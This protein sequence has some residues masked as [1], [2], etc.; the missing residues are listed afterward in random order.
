[1]GMCPYNYNE[2]FNKTGNNGSDGGAFYTKNGKTQNTKNQNIVKNQ[3]CNNSG[4]A[5]DHGYKSMTGFADGVNVGLPN[6]KGNQSNHHNGKIFT[7]VL[8]CK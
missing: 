1:M 6:C 4:N 2:T 3:I 5:G 7:A 8:Q